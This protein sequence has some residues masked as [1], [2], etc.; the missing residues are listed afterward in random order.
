MKTFGDVIDAGFKLRCS[1]ANCSRDEFLELS[2]FDRDRAWVGKTFRCRCGS[3][4]TVKVIDPKAEAY[5]RQ[6]EGW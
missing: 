3:E 4:A 6:T 2:R 5:K 1:C